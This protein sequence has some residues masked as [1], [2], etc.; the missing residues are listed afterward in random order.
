MYYIFKIFI[1]VKRIKID[2]ARDT[3]IPQMD[4]VFFSGRKIYD[5]A[6]L[7]IKR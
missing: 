6:S 3:F 4:D 7:V 5:M 2:I 1:F